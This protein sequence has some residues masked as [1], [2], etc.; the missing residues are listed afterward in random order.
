MRRKLTTGR[1]G[2]FGALVRIKG[3]TEEWALNQEL[4]GL[5]DAE[6]RLTSRS[7]KIAENV[8]GYLLE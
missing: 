3:K 5:L 1:A 4:C 8:L 7:H 2:Y 6:T